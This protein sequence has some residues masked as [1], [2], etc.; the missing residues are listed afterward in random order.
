MH[1][2]FSN[3]LRCASTAVR[4]LESKGKPP[5]SLNQATRTPLKLRSRFPAKRDP[6]SVMEM[7]QRGSGPAITLSN[8]AAS[9]TVLASGPAT[10]KV[11]QAFPTAEC[12]T[13]PGAVRK[14]ITL[15]NAAGFRNDPPL[16]LPSRSEEHTSELQSLRHLVCRLLLE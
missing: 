10:P 3:T 14:P 4:I 1:P 8:S 9:A 6:G 12:G 13:R 16:S 2:R 15:Q 11:A 5:I 7:G